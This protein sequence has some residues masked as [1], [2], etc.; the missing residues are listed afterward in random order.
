M[1]KFSFWS[2]SRKLFRI[3]L[4]F[5]SRADS[6][7]LFQM[8]GSFSLVSISFIWSVFLA[9]SKKPPE[10]GGLLLQFGEQAFELN[11]FHVAIVAVFAATVKTSPLLRDAAGPIPSPFPAL[12]PLGEGKWG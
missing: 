2:T 1:A 3:F 5:A 11:K 12:L 9:I 4:S 6:W 7:G 10:V 8:A